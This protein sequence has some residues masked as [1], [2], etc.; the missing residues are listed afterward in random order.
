MKK[1][2]KRISKEFEGVIR[3]NSKADKAAIKKDLELIEYIKT[4][5]GH[6]GAPYDLPMP[7]QKDI[8]PVNLWASTI[9][10]H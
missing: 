10:D 5:G 7:F 6:G 4:L 9:R 8:G 1:A 3:R 2:A